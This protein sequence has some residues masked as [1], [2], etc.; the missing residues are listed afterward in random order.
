MNN[1]SPRRDAVLHVLQTLG[2]M[3]YRQIASHLG[4]ETEVVHR[5]IANARVSKPEQ[6]FAIVG[7]LHDP[8]DVRT[9]DQSIYSA[10]GGEDVPR[11]KVKTRVRRIAVQARY[12]DKNRA[13]INASLRTRRAEKAGKAAP[14]ASPWAGLL[15]PPKRR[16]L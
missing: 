6:M 4:W 2:P 7:Y 8:N 13:R 11:P 1:P 5:T 14:V 16:K 3:T 12:R 15:N 9:K 10:E